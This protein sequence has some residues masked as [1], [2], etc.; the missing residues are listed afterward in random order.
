M[1]SLR[2]LS[3]AFRAWRRNRRW[4]KHEPETPYLA[5]L[6]SGVPVCLHVGASDGR[7]SYV[8]T[9]VAP[10]ARIWAFEP[11]AFAFEVLKTT[12]AWHRIGRQVTP[13]H[14]AV[15]D[16]PGELLLVTPKKTSGRMGRA[17]AY[18]AETRPNGPA[19]P[20]LEDTGMDVQPTPVLTLDAFCR[21]HGIDKVDFIRMDIE[22]A[23]LKA[24]MGALEIL[25]RD[26]PHVLLEIH[27]DMLQARFGAS[28][29]AVLDIFRDRG[30][31]MFA[32]NGDRLEE[33]QTLVEGLPWKDYFFIHP[34]KAG[35]LPDGVFKARMAA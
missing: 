14:A 23:E 7:H 10:K 16:Q 18:V 21:E 22:G 6:L 25:D 17:Y 12:I 13:I 33:R 29:E 4:A 11:S 5:D 20:D 32:L 1:P 30:Y 28:G 31:R 2:V 8:M 34:S 24:L 35:R 9:Q 15:A 26:R 27:P 3:H 19:R